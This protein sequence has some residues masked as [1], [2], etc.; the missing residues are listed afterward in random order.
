MM[1]EVKAMQVTRVVLLG[2]YTFYFNGSVNK[3][4]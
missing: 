3:T 1:T 4:F 2:D